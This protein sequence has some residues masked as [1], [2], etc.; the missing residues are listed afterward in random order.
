M[1]KITYIVLISSLLLSLNSCEWVNT[2]ILGNPSKAEIAKK[3]EAENARIDS[4]ARIEQENQRLV[5]EK[6]EQEV[7]EA[8]QVAEL[9]QRYHVIVGCFLME[10]NAD[11]MMNN[12]TKRGYSP[13]AFDFPYGY[14]CISAQS[15]G[16]LNDAYNVMAAMLRED[17][18][19]P[20]D[21]WLYDINQQLHK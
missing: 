16:N 19:W 11:R 1:K 21:I 12:L 5:A 15:F 7:A 9:N 10:E 20:D 8:K 14:T 2:T 18:L 3:Q 6:V 4:L 17:D 13:Q